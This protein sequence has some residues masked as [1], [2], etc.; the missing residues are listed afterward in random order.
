MT[1][2]ITDARFTHL[3]ATPRYILALLTDEPPESGWSVM[4]GY[5]E[6]VSFAAHLEP[7]RLDA[8]ETLPSQVHPSYPYGRPKTA[9][10]KPGAGAG[11][12]GARAAGNLLEPGGRMD[13]KWEELDLS[14]V[15]EHSD[16]REV[17]PVMAGSKRPPSPSSPDLRPHHVPQ[18]RSLHLRRLLE[19]QRHATPPVPADPFDAPVPNETYAE[20]DPENAA[21]GAEQDAEPPQAQ[22][23]E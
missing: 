5:D 7:P 12:A 10:S 16:G 19:R 9:G 4:P 17:P 13:E 1:T 6:N 21:R 11:G 18:P 22:T 15:L 3:H 23:P 8:D 2:S 14:A 20:D